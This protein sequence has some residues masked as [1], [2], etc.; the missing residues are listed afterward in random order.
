MRDQP[1]NRV[2]VLAVDAVTAVKALMEAMKLA[3]PNREE[4]QPEGYDPLNP[5]RHRDNSHEDELYGIPHTE[6]WEVDPVAYYDFHNVLYL[7]SVALFGVDC[8]GDQAVMTDALDRTRF[9]RVYFQDVPRLDYDE[10]RHF[11]IQ[12]ANLRN[13]AENV[14]RMVRMER[15]DRRDQRWHNKDDPPGVPKRVHTKTIEI[16]RHGEVLTVSAFWPNAES[17]ENPEKDLCCVTAS[18]AQQSSRSASC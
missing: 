12:V 2:E 4:D 17:D 11:M 7:L 15:S 6:S 16:W 8:D 1:N 13:A 10:T 3:W 5:M 9:E 14:D 18:T